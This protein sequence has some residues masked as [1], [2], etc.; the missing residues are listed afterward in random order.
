MKLFPHTHPLARRRRRNAHTRQSG[1]RAWSEIPREFLCC[2]GERR[3]DHNSRGSVRLV[4][5][6]SFLFIHFVFVT[7]RR[8]NLARF[9]TPWFALTMR[10]NSNRR[11]CATKE[12]LAWRRRDLS[13][14]TH[15]IGPRALFR[16]WGWTQ[17]H[18]RSREI[19]WDWRVLAEN[20]RRPWTSAH[21]LGQH[22]VQSAQV[23][24]LWN[25]L[26]PDCRRH[27]AHADYSVKFM[28][29]FSI[30]A[31]FLICS[32]YQSSF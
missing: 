25:N 5:A 24:H 20:P 29:R 21:F 13:T 11:A 14:V 3:N 16:R 26:I 6:S 8:S 7:C 27:S 30:S 32:F 12:V 15:M 1:A 10:E 2:S 28:L 22:L 17:R 31:T 19:N 18:S 9:L 4:S 23:L